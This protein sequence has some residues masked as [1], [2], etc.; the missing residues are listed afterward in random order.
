MRKQLCVVLILIV[1]SW[2]AVDSHAQDWASRSWDG[3]DHGSLLRLPTGQSL[4]PTAAPGSTFAP[5]NPGLAELPSYTAGQAVTTAVSPDG[6]TLLVLTSGYNLEETAS[7]AENP[8]LSDE[9]V[10]VYDI[11]AG[12]PLQKQVLR[13]P[14][15]Y[16]GLVFAPNG[17]TFYVGGGVDDSVHV[18]TSSGGVWAE[19][20]TPITLNNGP[21]NSLTKGIGSLGIPPIVGAETAGLAVS[22]DGS[23]V[24]VANYENDSI[25]IV[26]V[27]TRTSRSYDLR[28]G[29]INPA[30]SGV[31]GGEF[32]YWVAFKGSNTVYVSSQR[33]REIVEVTG[34]PGT[35]SVSAR[36]PVIGN[37]NKMIMNSAQTRLFV[38]LD[39]SDAVDVIDTGT[40]AVIATIPTT[41]PR[42]FMRRFRPGSTPNSLALSPDERTLYV[43]NA[44]SNSVAVIELQSGGASGEVRGLIP[45]GWYPNSVSVGAKGQML[46]VV[47]AKSSAGPNPLNCTDV[48]QGPSGATT[49]P[50]QVSG[51]PASNQNGSGN[52]YIWQ[53]TK[54]GLL[55]LP[56]PSGFTLDALT[57]RVASNNGFD[58]RLSPEDEAVIT[59]LKDKIKH[60]IY[61]IKENRTYDQVLGDLPQGNGDPKLTQFPRSITPNFHSI[62]SKFVLLDNFYCSSEVSMDGWQWSTGARTVDAD[63]K[64]TPVNYA[65]RGLFNDSEGTSRDINVALPTNAQRTAALSAGAA[66]PGVPPLPLAVQELSGQPLSSLADPDA[67]PGTGYEFGLDGP[68]GEVGAGYIW[69]AALRAGKTVRNYG[70]FL[71][72][73]L[74]NVP[75]EIGGLPLLTDPHAANAPVA[76]SANPELMA[77]T[78][79]Y[80]RGF[81]NNFPD[82]FRYTE[83]ARE[84]AGY[85]A[86]GNLP[87]LELLRV[88]HDHMGN[89]G[90]AIA[91]VNT[92][93]LQQ[94]DDDYAVGL[95]VQAVANST[96]AGNTLIFVLE[97]DAQDGADHV[98]AHRS[99]AYLV[100]PYVKHGA[101]V[102]THYTTVN[103][104]RTIEDILGLQHLNIHDHGVAPMTQAFDL[105]QAAWTYTATP[106]AYLYNTQLPLPTPVARLKI[107]KSTHPASWWAARTR[108]M[109]FSAEDRIDPRAFNLL[110]WRGLKGNQ[111]YPMA[112]SGSLNDDDNE[113][114]TRRG[115]GD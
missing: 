42:Q 9:Y 58:L 81:D 93:E 102:S 22:A 4:S 14:N 47:N 115:A 97:D 1:G 60:V 108:G 80:F 101:T 56:V 103:M 64:A 62:A 5:L 35:P 38:A 74:Y 65:N 71:D 11:S 10:F 75:P 37:P 31:P 13:L 6:R 36:I 100:G 86:N 51:C 50:L 16:L 41:A 95:I 55:T 96:Y 17:L 26:N 113:P 76:I 48:N 79:P 49:A 29:K 111:P 72:L 18:F 109:D 89:F 84:F 98:D 105:S 20:G 87:Q 44:G 28:P 82:Y 3:G 43:T 91:G 45:T 30:M 106:S 39:N 107:P 7:G 94:A 12:K 99:T 83:W 61:I 68:E 24:V 70:F 104:L 73:T 33:D 69:S 67:L 112:R 78:D 90:T 25:S 34:L 114:S 2:V 8:A 19:S 23:T 57:E 77:V 110:V 32:P 15:T 59:G 85:V 54:A 63:D 66:V 52:Q 27:A 46:Y 88:M 53:L 21:G 40:N 92:P